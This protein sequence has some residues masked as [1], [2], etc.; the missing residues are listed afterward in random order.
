MHLQ[1]T[2]LRIE[3]FAIGAQNLADAELVAEVL[4]PRQP[5]V[6]AKIDRSH[7]GAD[8]SGFKSAQLARLIR[9]IKLGD[10]TGFGTS[11]SAHKVLDELGVTMIPFSS[12]QVIG[13]IHIEQDVEV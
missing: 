1:R 5:C 10:G 2:N 13:R 11:Q 4:R 3:L 7:Q 12:K 6:H 9:D 8:G